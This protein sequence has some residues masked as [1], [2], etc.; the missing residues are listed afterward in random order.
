MTCSS[1]DITIIRG[2]TFQ[3]VV[4]WESTPFLTKAITGITKAAPPVVTSASHG[5]TTGWKVAVVGVQGMTEINADATDLKRLRDSDFHRVIVLT[6]STIELNEINASEYTTYSSG[7]Y[8]VWYTPASLSGYT[9][10]M[11]I[12]DTFDGTEIVELVSPTDIVLDDTAKTITITI[13]DTVTEAI[14]QNYGVY[15]LEMISAGLV[16][17]KILRGTVTIEDEVT[18]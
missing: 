13:A 6:S 1:Q 14:T 11:T 17:T 9:A 3:K 18:T 4:R 12:R 5:L 8:L 16:V 15:D 7:G 2:D 10:R